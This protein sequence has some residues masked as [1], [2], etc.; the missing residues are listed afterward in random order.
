MHKLG[1][2]CCL[3]PSN[4]TAVQEET[5]LFAEAKWNSCMKTDSMHEQQVVQ[6]IQ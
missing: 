3:Q 6:S 4:A 2:K 1:K 5:E